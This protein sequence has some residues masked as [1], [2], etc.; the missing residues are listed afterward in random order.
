VIAGFPWN[1]ILGRDSGFLLKL[2]KNHLDTKYSCFGVLDEIE[3]FEE[4]VSKMFDWDYAPIYEKTTITRD[5][6]KRDELTSA[7]L[8]DLT[9]I[10]SLDIELYSHA[11]ERI[12]LINGDL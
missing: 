9:E 8:T 4:R 10:Q 3:A 6:P 1:R 7:V 2:A 12:K 5:R 11:L